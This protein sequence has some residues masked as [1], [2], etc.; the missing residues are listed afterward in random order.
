MGGGEEEGVVVVFGEAE[1]GGEVEPAVG[2]EGE[3]WAGWWH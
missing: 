3:G 1:A 2:V